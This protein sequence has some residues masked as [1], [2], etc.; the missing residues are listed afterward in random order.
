MTEFVIS[1]EK[2]RKKEKAKSL[3]GGA[4]TSHANFIKEAFIKLSIG[5]QRLGLEKMSQSLKKCE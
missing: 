1:K 3:K 4:T 2:E 5:S